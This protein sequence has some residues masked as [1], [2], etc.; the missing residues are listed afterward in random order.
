MAMN[1]LLYKEIF[2][3][4]PMGLF[5]LD[6]EYKIISW[7][8]WMIEK[9]NIS[10]V[11]AIGKTIDALFPSG[12]FDR[13]NGALEQ[14]KSVASPQIL[15][16][17]LNHYLIP[18]PLNTHEK[19][20][21]MQQHVEIYPLKKNSGWFSLVLIKDVTDTVHQKNILM[22]M[23][24]KLETESYHDILTGIF[25]RRFLWDWL[26]QQIAQAKRANYPIS[27]VMFDLDHF[28]KVNDD[29][30]HSAGDQV[31]IAF[32]NTINQTIRASDIFVRYGGEEFL[33]M[34]P[35]TNATSACHVANK[36]RLS[37]ENK[38][39]T[40]FKNYQVTCSAGI[41]IWDPSNPVSTQELVDLADRALYKA[42]QAG[43]NCIAYDEL[44]I[45]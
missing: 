39:Q 3:Y 14:I 19:I 26:D 15:S 23:A 24:F 8:T 31:L 42:K 17:I 38:L 44:L 11:D 22:E 37:W 5:I 13:F 6:D 7:N 30:G 1:D 29:Y 40:D 34:M 4:L 10:E 36:L 41:S 20:E 21:F 9:T 16:Q 32:A 18:I 28:K 43:R 33:L 25:N 35:E 12:N 2:Q 45:K 27:C